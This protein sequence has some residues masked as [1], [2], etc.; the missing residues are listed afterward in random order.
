[1]AKRKPSAAL[2]LGVF[3]GALAAVMVLPT[4]I[5]L[6][7]RVNHIEQNLALQHALSASELAKRVLVKE[8]SLSPELGR[9]LGVD[10]LQVRSEDSLLVH[11]GAGLDHELALAACETT[12]HAATVHTDDGLRW[13]VGC[14]DSGDGVQVVAAWSPRPLPTANVLYLVLLL[15]AAVGIVTSLGVLRLLS[16]LSRV[17]RALDRVGAGERGVR[18][19]STGFAEL[20]EL[21]DRLNAAAGAMEAREDAVVERISAVHKMARLVAHEVRNP[22]QSLELLA[23][24]VASE[25]DARERHEI[26]RSIRDEIRSLDMV[27]S[28]L[29]RKGTVDSGL[30]LIVRE[31]D[32]VP[33]LQQVMALRKPEADVHGIH[34]EIRELPDRLIIAMDQALLGRSLENLVLNAMQYVPP[35]RGH[36]QLRARTN[37]G[38]AEIVVED[39]GP[40]VD[41]D[42]APHIFDANVSGR[43]GG[44]G[45]GLALVKGVVDAH[46]GTISVDKSS[47]GGARFCLRLPVTPK[48]SDDNPHAEG[49]G[50]R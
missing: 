31:G 25:E 46:G 13:A 3:S 28:R 19:G 41:P 37:A 1:M 32:V 10:Y 18:L 7:R 4:A 47:L 36:V 43:T 14:A 50:R 49:A 17:S 33:L 21:V 20:D 30:Q 11:Q 22:L 39:N 6:T 45:L 40:G 16:P 27:V 34:I 24:L 48:E 9:E 2:V 5:P 8:G 42:L 44:T 26:V 29:L 23:T 38:F 12:E 15:A 35:G